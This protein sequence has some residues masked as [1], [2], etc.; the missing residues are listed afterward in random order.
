MNGTAKNKQR[1]RR[2]TGG[3]K[4]I[5]A[6]AKE[7]GLWYRDDEG[8][9]R[10]PYQKAP[11]K[12]AVYVFIVD[13]RRDRPCYVGSTHNLRERM[14]CYSNAKFDGSRHEDKINAAVKSKLDADKCVS[15]YYLTPDPSLVLWGE[16]GLKLSVI[17]GLE[18]GI[19]QMR[20]KPEWNKLHGSMPVKEM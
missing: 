2:M 4:F 6:G 18:Q 14:R 11:K 20:A 3:E 19:L 1:K 17:H 12:Q 15:V 8:G 5:A 16:T 7:L 10:F 13:S 9:A